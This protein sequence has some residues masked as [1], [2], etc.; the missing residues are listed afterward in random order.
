MDLLF[1]CMTK[2]FLIQRSNYPTVW[3]VPSPPV[4]DHTSTII[5]IVVQ[6]Y[7][8]TGCKTRFCD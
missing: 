7:V 8:K 2:H 5:V 1:N 4:Y 3:L 6:L